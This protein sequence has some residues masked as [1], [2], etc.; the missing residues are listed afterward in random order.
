M[1]IGL[2]ETDETIIWQP[3]FASLVDCRSRLSFSSYRYLA[4]RET[5]STLEKQLRNFSARVVFMGSGDFHHLAVPLIKRKIGKGPLS[6]IVFDRHL[7]AFPAPEGLVSC[8]SWIREVVKLPVVRRVVVIGSEDRPPRSLPKITVL[9]PQVF[10]RW[11]GGKPEYFSQFFST[12]DLYLSIDKD[13]FRTAL[14]SWG[15][16]DLSVAGLFAFLNR[17]LNNHRV[18]GVDVCGEYKPHGLWPTVEERRALAWNEKINIA[19]AR[20]FLRW[21]LLQK[22]RESSAGPRWRSAG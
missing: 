13:V 2:L 17:C 8:G 15:R 5:L 1:Q 20:F 4:S 18:I 14:T 6:V 12:V 9:S 16:G 7:D 22:Q 21:K 10:Y 19:L 3:R 11:L